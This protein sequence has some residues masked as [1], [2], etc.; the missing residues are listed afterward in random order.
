MFQVELWGLLLALHA[1]LCV[2]AG[3]LNLFPFVLNAL[4]WRCLCVAMLFGANSARA[5]G[6]VFMLGPMVWALGLVWALR[7]RLCV[8]C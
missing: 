2:V 5:L 3:V 4:C 8:C 7:A 1:R 6:L